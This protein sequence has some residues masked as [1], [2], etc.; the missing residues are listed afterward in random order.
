MADALRVDV[1]E[2]AEELVYI[3]FNLQNRHDRLQLVEVA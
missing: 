3:E 2:R 1:C